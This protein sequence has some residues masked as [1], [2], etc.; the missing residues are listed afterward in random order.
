MITMRAQTS[1]NVDWGYYPFSDHA[2]QLQTYLPESWT[3]Y[4]FWA[5][6]CGKEE[7]LGIGRSTCECEGPTYPV[8]GMRTLADVRVRCPHAGTEIVLRQSAWSSACHGGLWTPASSASSWWFGAESVLWRLSV[9]SHLPSEPGTRSNP[10]R[11][12]PNQKGGTLTLGGRLN[13]HGSMSCTLRP[14]ASCQ[15]LLGSCE[16]VSRPAPLIWVAGLG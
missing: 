9:V 14:W 1:V 8:L 12:V 15:P 10:S 13:P 7:A 6:P 2:P 4:F 3:L 5:Y 16:L 11:R